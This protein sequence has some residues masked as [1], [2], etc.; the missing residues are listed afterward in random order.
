MSYPNSL[1]EIWASL[2]RASRQNSLYLLKILF[3]HID[4][5]II[6]VELDIQH[7]ANHKAVPQMKIY[8]LP[9]GAYEADTCITNY[10]IRF[11]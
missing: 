6:F 1:H 5:A 8:T 10:N 4:I 3:P 7:F 9:K 2:N 11:L